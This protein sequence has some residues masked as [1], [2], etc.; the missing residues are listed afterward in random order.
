M[1]ARLFA[2]ILIG[3]ALVG[4][5]AVVNAVGDARGPYLPNNHTPQ[6]SRSR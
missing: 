5:V 3:L 2:V 6:P 1:A 4:S